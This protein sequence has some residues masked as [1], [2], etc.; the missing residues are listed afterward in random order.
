MVSTSRAGW[1]PLLEDGSCQ[2]CISAHV[3]LH[4]LDISTCGHTG[5]LNSTDPKFLL[6]MVPVST[7]HPS[8]TPWPY[9]RCLPRLLPKLGR[10]QSDINFISEIF[11]GFLFPLP[12]N[13]GQA[14]FLNLTYLA[15]T[16]KLVCRFWSHPPGHFLLRS[17]DDTSNCKSGHFVPHLQPFNGSPLPSGSSQATV[18]CNLDLSALPLIWPRLCHTL[19]STRQ[20]P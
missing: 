3:S 14:L 17:Q 2:V 1:E 20:V 10:A 18:C 6:V 12:T 7:H 11:L 13:R 9:P 16:L 8:W 4:L 15:P 5:L 19:P